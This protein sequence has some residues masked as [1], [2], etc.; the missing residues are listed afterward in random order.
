LL[1]DDISE[2]LSDSAVELCITIG[3]HNITNDLARAIR[4]A[5]IRN[6]RRQKV[7]LTI[8]VAEHGLYARATGG[9][10]ADHTD[11]YQQI[12]DAGLHHV[13][14]NTVMIS[15]FGARNPLGLIEAY[16]SALPPNHNDDDDG[17]GI[18][19]HCVELAVGQFYE[20]VYELVGIVALRALSV[21]ARERRSWRD[22][23]WLVQ[24]AFNR[25]FAVRPL[26][27]VVW[28]NNTWQPDG[29]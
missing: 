23:C 21:A 4:L 2:A 13:Q 17:F 24:A 29:M 10:L 12:R 5:Q 25:L 18:S 9:V 19:S 22:G 16:N 8:V 1:G 15:C 3:A 7:Q 11:V 27:N 6:R 20:P 14:V 26:L 28:Y